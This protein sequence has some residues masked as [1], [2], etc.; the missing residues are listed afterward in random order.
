MKT[1]T[2]LPAIVGAILTTRAGM[3]GK[4]V[5]FNGSKKSEY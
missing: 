1:I 5:P 2:F 4:Q 3:D